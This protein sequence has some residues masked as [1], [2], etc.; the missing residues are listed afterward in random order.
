[1][2][3]SISTIREKL[4]DVT[5]ENDSFF[6]ECL[7]DE[8]KGVEK[9]VQAVRRKWEK[10]AKLLVKLKEM[11]Q[12]ETELFQQ[13]YK[14]IAGVDEVGRGPIAGPVV[15]AAVILPTNFSVVGINDSKQLSEAKRDA[16]FETIK[17]EAI[18]IGVGIIEHDVID[19]VNIYEATKL[20]MRKALDQ[21][22]PE[23]D[24]VLIDAM[25]LRYTEAELSLIKGDTKSISIA[26]ASIIAKVTRDRL[27]QMYDEKYPGY[28]FAN[29][30]GYGTKKHLLG[31]DT[32]GIC[33]IH[34][35]SFSPVKEAKLH[36][37][38][39]N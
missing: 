16:L 14:Y 4:S 15:A 24:F 26:A 7:Q 37:D 13:G 18:A 25:P 6:Q 3:D 30:M 21:L 35:M 23:P 33:P 29:N 2:N 11:T 27:M 36:F 10:E 39:L 9:L 5:S 31:L 20:A 32:I 28:D 12:H 17:T 22:K 19:Q 38:S 1:M 34:R 8:R